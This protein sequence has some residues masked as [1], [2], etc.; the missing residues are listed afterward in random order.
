M[1]SR[2]LIFA[3][4]LSLAAFAAVARA[5]YLSPAGFHADLKT[6]TGIN[7]KT[8]GQYKTDAQRRAAA[9]AIDRYWDAVRRCALTIIPPTDTVI[10]SRLLDQFPQHLSIE[11]AADW[12]L[13]EGR[14]SKRKM[15]AFPSLDTPG[16]YSTSRREEQA[17][18]IK[19]V[20][21]LVGLGP[22]MAGEL[23]LWL[24]GNTNTL[25][26]ELSQVCAPLIPCFR[27]AYDNSPSEAWE[28]CEP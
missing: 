24:G 25:P 17:L 16:A 26:T 18:Y 27:F 7:V 13:V 3:T 8:N 14:V 15:Q 6:P 4:L 21:E 11:I 19:V 12:S 22:Q 10:R 5:Q 2:S 23:N 28:K 9:A 20:P 1:T